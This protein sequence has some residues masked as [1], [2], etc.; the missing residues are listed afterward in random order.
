MRRGSYY[1]KEAQ[2]CRELATAVKDKELALE[3]RRVARDYEA[4][5]E[6]ADELSGLPRIPRWGRWGSP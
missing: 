2:R 1:Q 3:W 6:S 4:L 5:A